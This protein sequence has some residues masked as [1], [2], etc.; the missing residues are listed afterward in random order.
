M[1]LVLAELRGASTGQEYRDWDRESG[2]DGD[3]GS[4]GMHGGGGQASWEERLREQYSDDEGGGWG[5]GQGE[6]SA[7]SFS[8]QND[9]A[10]NNLVLHHQSIAD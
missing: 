5:R 10:E 9:L 4:G 2:E 6:D 1:C 8:L 3:D 7:F